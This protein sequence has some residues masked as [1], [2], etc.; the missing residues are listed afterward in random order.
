[1]PLHSNELTAI[2]S[3]RLPKLCRHIFRTSVD[4]TRTTW[5]IGEQSKLSLDLLFTKAIPLSSIARISM[6]GINPS[7]FCLII[8]THH[9]VVK[10]RLGYALLASSLGRLCGCWSLIFPMKSVAV[11][12]IHI[13]V[14]QT[15]CS[16]AADLCGTS[17]IS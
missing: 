16:G 2:S 14:S 1:M 10:G 8:S 9:A 4:V 12:C 5:A 15:N 17:Q 11:C 13:L 3:Q 6:L 7:G